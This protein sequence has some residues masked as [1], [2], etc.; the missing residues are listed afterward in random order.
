[1]SSRRHAGQLL[2]VLTG[3]RRA[4][5]RRIQGRPTASGLHLLR[6]HPHVVLGPLFWGF[7]KARAQEQCEW[8]YPAGSSELSIEG[9]DPVRILVIGDGPAAGCG[10]LIHELGIAGFLARHIAEHIGRGVLVTVRAQPAA[11]ARSTLKGL[12]DVNLELYD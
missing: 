4:D 12:D 7:F 5:R 6:Q 9:I 11:S 3:G 10:V 1:M 2:R 8:F